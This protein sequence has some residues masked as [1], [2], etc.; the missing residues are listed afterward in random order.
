MLIKHKKSVKNTPKEGNVFPLWALFVTLGCI[1]ATSL[2]LSS[3]LVKLKNTP[4]TENYS[5]SLN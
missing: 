3:R 2:F 5:L 4:I 1:G